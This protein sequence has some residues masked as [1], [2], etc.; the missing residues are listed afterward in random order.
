MKKSICACV[1]ENL[2]AQRNKEQNCAQ[3]EKKEKCTDAELEVMDDLR[4]E[5]AYK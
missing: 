4:G 3:R 5:P 1:C 2:V